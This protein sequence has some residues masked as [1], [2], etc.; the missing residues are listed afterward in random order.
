[1]DS[2]SGGRAP[3]SLGARPACPLPPLSGVG[4]AQTLRLTRGAGH[5]EGHPYLRLLRRYLEHF[6]PRPRT[7]TPAANGASPSRAPLEHGG[8]AIQGE[9]WPRMDTAR[10]WAAH[11]ALPHPP[12]PD[13]WRRR[14]RAALAALGPMRVEGSA[15]VLNAAVPVAAVLVHVPRLQQG[16]PALPATCIEALAQGEHTPPL[17]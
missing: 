5:M 8:T 17:L 15:R 2:A 14:S 11:P 4:G 13:D 7:E 10:A 16:R 12:H 3:A 1:M 6:L 9:S